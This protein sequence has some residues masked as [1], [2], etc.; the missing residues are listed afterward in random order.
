[1]PEN[2]YKFN[3]KEEMFGTLHHLFEQLGPVKK[4]I[5]NTSINLDN[6]DLEEIKSVA[7]LMNAIDYLDAALSKIDLVFKL[8]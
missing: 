2:E 3:S 7:M 8:E 1:M 4:A 5:E 6:Y